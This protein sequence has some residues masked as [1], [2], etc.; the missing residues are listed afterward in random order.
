MCWKYNI[1]MMYGKDEKT[2]RRLLTSAL[3]YR[4]MKLVLRL[5]L[6]YNESAVGKGA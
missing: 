4:C 2:A 6:G 5:I 3:I 1:Y